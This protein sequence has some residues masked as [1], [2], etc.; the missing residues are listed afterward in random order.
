MNF[1]PKPRAK[2][3]ATVVDTEKEAPGEPK[4]VV[5]S[6][7]DLNDKEFSTIANTEEFTKVWGALLN[8]KTK[9]L[10]ECTWDTGGDVD[11]VEQP[12]GLKLVGPAAVVSEFENL[13]LQAACV[14]EAQAALATRYTTTEIALV[15]AMY[16]SGER[17]KSGQIR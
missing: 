14:V 17:K 5:T 16:A 15:V 8:S 1:A 10:S 3:P 7:F 13:L 12:Q 2:K 6:H 11:G 4:N 9:D